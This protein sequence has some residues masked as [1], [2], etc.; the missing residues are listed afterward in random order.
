[1]SDASEIQSMPEDF[2]P[3]IRREYHGGEEVRVARHEY[4]GKVIELGYCMTNE[5]RQQIPERDRA[6]R[7]AV[8]EVR[9]SIRLGR[10]SYTGV[11]RSDGTG[12]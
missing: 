8:W 7:E 3:E 10:V 2:F 11:I 4:A 6:L 12:I 9:E 5:T 1:M